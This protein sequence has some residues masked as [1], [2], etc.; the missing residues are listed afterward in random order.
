MNWRFGGCLAGAVFLAT[1]VANFADP[2]LRAVRAAD[3]VTPE[4][5]KSPAPNSPDEPIADKFS[6]EKAVRFL[7]AAS[8]DWQKRRKCMT[9]HTNYSYLLSRP[10][11]S[12]DVPAHRAVREYAEKLVSERWESKGPRWPAEVIC[13]ATALAFNDAQT[14]GKLH[15]LTR[16]ALDRMWT[17]QREDGGFDWLKCNWPPMESDDHYGVTFAAIGVGVAP[18]E[19]AQTPAAKKGLE[20]IRRYLKANPPPTLHHKAMVLWASTYVGGLMSEK[21]KK[22]CI[23][24]LLSLQRPGGGWGLAA[25]GDWKRADGSPQDMEASDGYGAGFVIYV[26]RRAGTPASHPQIALGV[27]WLL[28]NQR[29]SGRWFTRS[30]KLDN[31]HFITHAGTAYAVMALAECKD[32]VAKLQ[33]EP[34]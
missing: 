21:E 15:H 13:T 28:E 31:K 25:L 19:Y 30:M 5:F 23:K 3:P 8:L 2:S 32:V 14:T 29:A 33:A 11:V 1:V 34:K 16:K 17:L 27:K 12:A 6:L 4:N 22:A 20:N 26:L 24:E 9:C 18:G 7:D 10:H